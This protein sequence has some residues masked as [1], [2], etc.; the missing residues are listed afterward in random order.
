MSISHLSL[1]DFVHTS[2]DDFADLIDAI[3]SHEFVPMH[4]ALVLVLGFL[5]VAEGERRMW[6]FPACIH[7]P[8]TS[9]PLP[10]APFFGSYRPFCSA[11][12]SRL[13]RFPLLLACS[14]ACISSRERRGA[15]V[16]ETDGPFTIT[17]IITFLGIWGK[18]RLSRTPSRYKRSAEPSLPPLPPP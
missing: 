18:G 5:A 11:V 13:C 3:L 6:V 12:P 7:T 2:F 9:L 1:R 16:Q 17:T 4:S 15:S 14:F 8:K 10:F